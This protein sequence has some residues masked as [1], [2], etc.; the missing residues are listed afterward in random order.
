MNERCS[1]CGAAIKV[2]IMKGSGVCSEDCRKARA[3]EF[4][5]P[6]AQTDA[7]ITNLLAK[8]NGVNLNGIR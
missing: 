3:G 5:K 7:G 4:D 8:P 1:E 6:S 2:Q